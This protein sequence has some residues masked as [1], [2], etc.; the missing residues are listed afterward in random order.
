MI[1]CEAGSEKGTL[2]HLELAN[3]RRSLRHV[4]LAF[5]SR[6]LSRHPERRTARQ[7]LGPWPMA[8][9]EKARKE[10]RLRL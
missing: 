7:A 4:K 10:L 1:R 3:S 9:K 2:T 8:G 5:D 6:M